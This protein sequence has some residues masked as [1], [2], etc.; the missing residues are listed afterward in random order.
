M[1]TFCVLVGI[2][3]SGKSTFAKLKAEETDSIIISSDEYRQ[4]LYGN[5][6]TQGD[7]DKLFEIIQEDIINLLQQETDVIFDATNISRK[8]RK[9]LLDRVKKVSNV[10][11]KCILMATQYTLCLERNSKR[12]RVVPEYV[13]KRMREN[14]NIPTYQEGFDE[15]EI[16]YDYNSDD[17]KY[18]DL[19]SKMTIFNQNNPHHTLTLGEHS[20]RV[21]NYLAENHNDMLLPYAGVF[22]DLGKLYTAVY[23]DMKGNPTEICHYYFHENVGCYESL[24]YLDEYRFDKD[25][26]IEIATLI[27]YHMRPYQALTDK[28]KIKLLDIVGQRVYDNLWLLNE[29]DKLNH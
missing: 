22:H 18:T 5:E 24:F 9:P 10:Q 14:F 15:I 3:G 1:I 6:N 2:V 4:R 12:E 13:I 7:N 17:Y 11:I 25:E 28:S 20:R 21:C 29:A 19:I 8:Y 27:L 23:K 26:I 16:V